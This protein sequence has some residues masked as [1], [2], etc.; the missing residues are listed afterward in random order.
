MQYGC[1]TLVAIG[2]MASR[3][4]WAAPVA[5]VDCGGFSATGAIV[6][7]CVGLMVG[8]PS[9]AGANAAFA[10]DGI[11][12]A[13]FKDADATA[14]SGDQV[15]D[16]VD[17]GDDSV[18]IRFLRD[19]GDGSGDVL[20]GLKFGGRGR[21]QLGYFRFDHADFDTNDLLTLRWSQ[22]F[23]ADDLAHATVYSTVPVATVPE[24]GSLGLLLCGLA[25]VG[26][27]ARRN[28]STP[29]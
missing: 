16:V 19:V 21:N 2:L 26:G 22:P 29:S 10:G 14:A 8:N 3:V 24:P 23:P 4:A 7:Q 6:S 12:G 15:F 9:L 20:V 25:I 28:R 11:Y 5:P 1:A 27:C 18:T 17:N 13:E